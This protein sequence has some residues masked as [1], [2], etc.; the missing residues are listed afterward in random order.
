MK[1]RYRG[2]HG[3][4]LAFHSSRH[5]LQLHLSFSPRFARIA[6]LKERTAMTAQKW[7]LWLHT[8]ISLAQKRARK[9][10]RFVEVHVHHAEAGHQQVFAWIPTQEIYILFL[11]INFS[12]VHEEP[13][14]VRRTPSWTAHRYRIRARLGQCPGPCSRLSG[15]ITIPLN[16]QN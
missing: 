2:H 8:S 10:H 14:I 13:G 1:F 6:A 3:A 12:S 4:N 11:W 5:F 9:T 15:I 16:H 7:V